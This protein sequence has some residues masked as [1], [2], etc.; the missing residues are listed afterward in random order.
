MG[1]PGY[2][3]DLR[4]AESWLAIVS[5]RLAGER[6]DSAQQ[7]TRWSLSLLINLFY[8]CGLWVFIYLLRQ[9]FSV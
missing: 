7:L 1:K 8:V 6:V 9:G 4:K 5:G 3:I 2:E